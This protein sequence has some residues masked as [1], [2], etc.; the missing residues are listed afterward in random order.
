MPLRDDLLTAIPG[1]APAGASLRYDRVYDQIKEARTEVDALLP[2]WPG[3]PSPRAA[4]T[5]SWRRGL[6]KLS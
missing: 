4:R 6:V 5:C 3:K 1:D 2:S